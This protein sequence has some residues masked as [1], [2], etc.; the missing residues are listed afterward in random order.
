[1]TATL[2]TSLAS[3]Y[4]LGSQKTTSCTESKATTV[5][6]HSSGGDALSEIES[7]MPDYW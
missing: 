1:M 3:S 2:Q 4:S 5:T 6:F 7:M